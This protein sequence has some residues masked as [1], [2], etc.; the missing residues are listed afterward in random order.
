MIRDIGFADASDDSRAAKEDAAGP[1]RRGPRAEPTP[2]LA[3]DGW[4]TPVP[5]T[6]RLHHIRLSDALARFLDRPLS[7]QGSPGP[8]LRA[9]DP[10]APKRR[11][12]RDPRAVGQCGRT[13]R[14]GG[15]PGPAQP[16][17]PARAR[18]PP[19]CA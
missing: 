8:F 6:C 14:A 3:A 17:C 15:V 2:G 16:P 13:V 1:Q 9:P 7:F 5:P 11:A 10:S 12:T 18:R 19:R 4:V